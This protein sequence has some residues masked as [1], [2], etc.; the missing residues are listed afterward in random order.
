MRL[1][2]QFVARLCRLPKQEFKIQTTIETIETTFV[3]IYLFKAKPVVSIVSIVVLIICLAMQISYKQVKTCYK[4]KIDF[5][6][7]RSRFRAFLPSVK[8]HGLSRT[9]PPPSYKATFTV[10]NFLSC[11]PIVA[12]SGS[13]SGTIA[14]KN[15]HF[16]TP[17]IYVRQPPTS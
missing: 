2:V 14:P 8:P 7:F 6:D 12:L 10:P 16:N 4:I 9:G 15:S 3:T 1:G 17:M 5:R 11:T 13:N